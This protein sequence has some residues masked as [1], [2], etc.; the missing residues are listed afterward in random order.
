MQS[1]GIDSAKESFVAAVIKENGTVVMPS[2]QFMQTVAGFEEFAAALETLGGPDLVKLGM[3]STGHYG[4]PLFRF[5]TDK[6]YR[7]DMFNPIL[8]GGN[9]S[10]VRG[11][12]T[13][14]DDAVQIAKIIRDGDYSPVP[15]VPE[16]ME[17]LRALCRQR[18]WFVSSMADAKR[19]L[20][21]LMDQLFPEM[22]E[23]V[24]NL[25]GRTAFAMMKLDPSASGIA[26]MSQEKIGK[27]VD[28]A[29][30][31][32]AMAGFVEKIRKLA[33]GSVC[34]GVVNQAACRCVRMMVVQ[35]EFL[36][37]QIDT[38]EPEIAAF[39]ETI[40][41]PLK[42]VP[43]IGKVTG[44]V[45]AAELG[46]LSRFAGPK[47]AKRILA[48]VGMD[49]RI[50]Q[51]G[52]WTGKMKMTKR[53]SPDLRTALFQAAE[54]GRRFCPAF[55]EIYRRQK[56][57]GKHHSVAVSH[58]ARKIIEVICGMYKTNRPFDVNKIFQIGT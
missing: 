58:V 29:S 1:A 20:R 32:H 42:T 2:R 53:G 8:S 36:Q 10:N 17:Q 37:G 22:E 33:K 3:E 47:M 48:Y 44:P 43:G 9:K 51:S 27:T 19:R 45:I 16:E 34:A 31:G 56:E 41:L 28:A 50:R 4:L 13:D 26:K 23:A 54:M 52:T 21:S 6:G 40:E 18:R 14:K 57:R 5:L 35:I 7:V 25:F 30:R 11:R 15:P 55:A 39:Y 12:K 46:D 49:P 38:L 24:S